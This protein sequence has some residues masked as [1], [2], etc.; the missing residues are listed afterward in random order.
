[1]SSVS[2]SISPRSLF[3]LLSCASWIAFSRAASSSFLRSIS[4]FRALMMASA[5]ALAAA[6]RSA[7]QSRPAL[8]PGLGLTF[9]VGFQVWHRFGLLPLGVV[10]QL[11]L[12]S[13][14]RRFEVLARL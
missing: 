4:S 7:F 12:M 13:G 8:T 11:F 14:L 9:G 2:A 5:S 10:G 6:A 1:M 3:H